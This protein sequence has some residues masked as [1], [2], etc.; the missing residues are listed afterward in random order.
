MVYVEGGSTYICTGTLLNDTV[1]GTQVPWFYSAHHCISTQAVASTLNTHWN[2]EATSCGS[3][4]S[5][6]RSI[7]G[8]GADYMFSDENTD[9]L[10]LKLR[11]PAPA[12]AMF[13]GWDAGPLAASSEVF[14]IHHPAGDA[15]K[16][17]SGQHVPADSDAVSHAAGWLSGT[18][19]GGS[20]GSGLFTRSGEGF[21]LRGGLYGGFASCANTGSLSNTD[22]RD[23]YSRFDVVFPD[24]R[25]HIAPQP[26]RRN[27]S[28]PLLPP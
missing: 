28:Q 26:A 24:I 18:T 15:R 4:V 5:T 10:L 2:Y 1:P 6:T 12:V 27:G 14:A 21:R 23:W 20:S 25:Q 16:V 8:G 3:G 13:A 11:N 7:L 17:S 9:A 22:N 19:E